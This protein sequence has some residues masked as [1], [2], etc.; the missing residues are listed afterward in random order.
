MRVFRIYP[1]LTIGLLLLTGVGIALEFTWLESKETWLQVL[2]G[3][4]AMAASFVAGLL[5]PRLV[6]LF[7][8]WIS[9]LGSIAVAFAIYGVSNTD[10]QPVWFAVM[11]SMIYG[12]AAYVV[13]G[14]GWVVRGCLVGTE[15]SKDG[16]L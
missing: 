3:V 9:V 2:V 6:N 13:F 4:V 14:V 1:P 8:V 15:R 16:S 10:V 12:I 5:S 7:V 11:L